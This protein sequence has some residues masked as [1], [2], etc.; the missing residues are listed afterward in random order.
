M[1]ICYSKG[2]A[3]DLDTLEDLKAYEYMEPGLLEALTEGQ[4]PVQEKE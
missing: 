4:T 2:L 3:F 1:A